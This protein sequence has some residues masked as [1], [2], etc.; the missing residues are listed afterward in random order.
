MD[1]K[2]DCLPELRKML[3]FFPVVGI[4]GARQ[5]GKTTLA[6]QLA[7]GKKDSVYLDLE[8]SRDRAKLTDPYLFL[9]N[10]EGRLVILDEIQFMPELMNELRS[11]I[12]E[13]RVPGRFIVLGSASAELIK[14]SSDSLAGRIGYYE[15][16]P[17]LQTEIGATKRDQLWLRGGFPDSFGAPSE[18]LSFAWRK[19]FVKSYV[20]RDLPQLGLIVEAF[21]LERFWRMLA[22]FH[23][24]LWNAENF[25]RALGVTGNTVNRYL[26]FMENAFLL[27]RL[28][29]YSHNIKKRL[30]KSPK[31]YLTDSGIFHYLN[32]IQN[33]EALQ[34]THLIGAS[35]EGYVIEQIKRQARDRFQYFFYR[36][37]QGTECD[38][39]L[40]RSGRIAAAIEIKYS[41]APTLTK[42]FNLALEDLIPAKSFVIVP[43]TEG[44]PLSRQTMVISLSDFLTKKLDKI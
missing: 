35:W 25:G 42:G 29:P 22:S 32:N 20:E 24:N 41:S 11:L 13:N 30:V 10:L 4:L 27:E 1:I 12:D 33:K 15:L 17:F 16:T 40:E 19:N 14:K 7:S 44:F 5:V 18:A 37:H 6:K 9:K 3:G 21:T 28:C 8:T 39:I 36:T 2:R 43:E 31:V 34:N 38:L 26:N 23:G